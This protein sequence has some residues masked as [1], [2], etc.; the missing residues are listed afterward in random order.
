MIGDE[1]NVRLSGV[2]NS[3]IRDISKIPNKKRLVFRIRSEQAFNL[4]NES[5]WIEHQIKVSCPNN[6]QIIETTYNDGDSICLSGKL[7]YSEYGTTGKK[8]KYTTIHVGLNDTVS[9]HPPR[10]PLSGIRQVQPNQQQAPVQQT[11]HNPYD[12]QNQPP[13]TYVPQQQQPAT[14][15]PQYAPQQPIHAPPPPEYQY[16]QQHPQ[17]PGYAPQQQQPAPATHYP[18]YTPPQAPAGYAPQSTQLPNTGSDSIK[19]DEIP[20]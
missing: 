16:T 1:N 14:A 4:E 9:I 2:I 6:I 5:K 15:Q 17:H 20:F 10:I 11:A 18:Q 12:Y 3:E 7:E 8:T 13:P 19:D